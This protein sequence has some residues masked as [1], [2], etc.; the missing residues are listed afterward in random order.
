MSTAAP[1]GCRLLH[2][3]SAK[4][5]CLGVPVSAGGVAVPSAGGVV[6]ESGVVVVES[7]VV[8]GTAPGS[9]GVVVVLS[10]GGMVDWSAGGVVSDGAVE[11]DSCFAHADASNNAVTLR[12]RALRFIGSPHN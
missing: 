7:G 8:G 5:Y 3:D 11:A 4:P 1:R 9:A 10:A 2:A 12:N 6:V